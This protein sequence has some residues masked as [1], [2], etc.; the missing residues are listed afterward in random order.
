[1]PGSAGRCSRSCRK[2][3]RPP[4]EAPTPTIQK[5]SFESCWGFIELDLSGRPMQ[6]TRYSLSENN[7]YLG[8]RASL[9]SDKVIDRLHCTPPPFKASTFRSCAISVPAPGGS[10]RSAS[11]VLPSAADSLKRLI[12]ADPVDGCSDLGN[13]RMA[14][15]RGLSLDFIQL[16]AQ[17][18]E[19][20]ARS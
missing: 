10:A 1:M 12:V 7:I 13:D 14:T 5:A 16:P 15:W 18:P 4:A 9:K 20:S 3:L 11:Q 2:A 19:F 17:V 8:L 6:S